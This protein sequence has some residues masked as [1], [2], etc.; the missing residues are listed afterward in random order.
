MKTL[1]KE[2]LLTDDRILQSTLLE[3]K[4]LQEANHP[5]LMG[6]EYAFQSNNTIYFVMKFVKGGELYMHLS[7]VRQFT[8]EQV[9]FYVV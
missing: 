5:F 3:K 8:D 9:K 2:K 7:I 1:A 6:T 4:I